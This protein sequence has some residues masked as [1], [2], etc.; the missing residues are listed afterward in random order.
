MH[1]E[2]GTKD[3]RLLGHLSPGGDVRLVVRARTGTGTGLNEHLVAVGH[4]FCTCSGTR[5]TRRS[6][7]RDSATTPTF[8]AAP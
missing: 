4:D 7:L 5:A 6:P 1:D 8:M 2:V 3:V